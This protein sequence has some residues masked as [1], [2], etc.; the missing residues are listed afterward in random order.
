MILKSGNAKGQPWRRKPRLQVRLA[1]G[2]DIALLRKALGLALAIDQQQS[3]IEVVLAEDKAKRARLEKDALQEQRQRHQLEAELTRFKEVI[4]T[5]SFEPV[6]GGVH[7][8]EDALY[9]MG[10][11]PETQPGA[12]RLRTRYRTLATIFH[13]DGANGDHQRMSQLN[14]AMETL[15]EH[16]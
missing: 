12:K 8:V 2:Y 13:P 6:Y 4:T 5:L 11:P 1:P 15:K 14:S 10:F 7:G 3:S 9:V 16:F